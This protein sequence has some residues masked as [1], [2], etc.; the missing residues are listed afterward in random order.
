[1]PSLYTITQDIEGKF[2]E[3]KNEKKRIE[4]KDI[5]FFINGKKHR[6]TKKS[7]ILKN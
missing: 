1:M 3:S 2:H 7:R 6:L 4:K 5:A